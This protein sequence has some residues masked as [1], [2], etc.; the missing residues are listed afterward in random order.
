MMST[1]YLMKLL[2]KTITN[3]YK[4]LSTFNGNYIE[5]ESKGD[6]DDNLSLEEFF[7]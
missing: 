6:N 2:K 1:I 4:L 5:Y 3:Q 7:S